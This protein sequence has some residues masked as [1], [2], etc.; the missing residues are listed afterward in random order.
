MDILSNVFISGELKASKI[1][2]LASSPETGIFKEVPYSSSCTVTFEIGCQEMF[3][4]DNA[5]SF[6]HSSPP[7]IMAIDADSLNYVQFDYR[8]DNPYGDVAYVYAKRSDSME[9]K[10]YIF[11]IIGVVGQ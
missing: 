5:S 11:T 9:E 6:R 7:L 10:T 8:I 2:T 3:V 1:Q 4:T